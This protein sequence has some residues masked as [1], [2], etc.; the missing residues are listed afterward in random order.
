VLEGIEVDD[1]AGVSTASSGSP[2]RAGM[3]CIGAL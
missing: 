1:Q 3:R 2:I